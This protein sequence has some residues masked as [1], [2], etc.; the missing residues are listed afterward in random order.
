M[1]SGNVQSRDGRLPGIPVAAA[2]IAAGHT[3]V[4]S[5]KKYQNLQRDQ[6]K[7][8]FQNLLPTCSQAKESNNK[9][10]ASN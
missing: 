3:L 4:Q 5:H 7:N 6:I 1:T 9:S 10:A 8:A 2:M